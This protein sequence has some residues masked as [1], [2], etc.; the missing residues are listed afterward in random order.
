MS[1]VHLAL[2][3]I[4]Y[5]KTASILSTSL[6]I[7]KKILLA[8]RIGV[9][10]PRLGFG[11][12][13]K[14][15]VFLTALE[16]WRTFP[17][18]PKR[19]STRRFL[20]VIVLYFSSTNA[21]AR[22][23]SLHHSPT[24]S[25]VLARVVVVPCPV[26]PNRATQ[27][28]PNYAYL[29]YR[30]ANNNSAKSWDWS[31]IVSTQS[32]QVKST[33][34]RV[35]TMVKSKNSPTSV[36]GGDE[37]LLYGLYKQATK[38]DAPDRSPFSFRKKNKKKKKAW[39]QLKEIPE[40]TLEEA[41]KHVTMALQ[42]LKVEQDHSSASL[43][44]KDKQSSTEEPSV[45]ASEGETADD[46]ASMT[47]EDRLL[48]AAGEDD[49]KTLRKLVQKGV[50]CQYS[51]DC[52]QTALHMAAD[53]GAESALRYLLEQGCEVDSV[54]QHGVSVLQAAVIAGHV[55]ICKILIEKGA[56]PDKSDEDGDSP[57]SCA[58]DDGSPEMQD[59]FDDGEE[60]DDEGSFEQESTFSW[61]TDFTMQ[62]NKPNMIDQVPKSL[63]DS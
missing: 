40:E 30:K 21:K 51:D 55:E 28:E 53:N 45:N 1:A 58:M 18:T 19:A 7:C 62:T 12:V 35:S 2:E 26:H 13:S 59:L 20:F 4:R 10:D 9:E 16:Y 15:A 14:P 61:K 31:T 27:T 63:L 37:E 50:S 56:D 44:E 49:V 5:T 11:L 57:Y 60:D 25:G 3:G 46:S 17:V 33:Q 48:Y 54:D 42:I 41:L 43:G 39:G 23:S 32:T 36:A 47:P 34:R 52:G 29:G 24:Q 6:G 8:S 38:G 22:S